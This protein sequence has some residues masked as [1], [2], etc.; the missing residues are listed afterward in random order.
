[1]FQDEQTWPYIILKYDCMILERLTPATDF[2]DSKYLS[3]SFP[4]HRPIFCL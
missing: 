2:S 4:F 1:M 3:F